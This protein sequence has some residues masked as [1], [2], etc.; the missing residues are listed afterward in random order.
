MI[1]KNFKNIT[2]ISTTFVLSS[3]ILVFANNPTINNPA[4]PVLMAYQPS[5]QSNLNTVN[6]WSEFIQRQNV[7]IESMQNHFPVVVMAAASENQTP[8][9]WLA[10]SNPFLMSGE[11]P[12]WFDSWSDYIEWLAH[13]WNGEQN[14]PLPNFGQHAPFMLPNLPENWQTD[15]LIWAMINDN[16]PAFLGFYPGWQGNWSNWQ[17]GFPGGGWNPNW[18]NWTFPD[19]NWSGWS[20]TLPTNWRS[21]F[22]NSFLNAMPDGW[23]PTW[24]MPGN[25]LFGFNNWNWHPDLHWSWGA[26]W[27]QSWGYV[28]NNPGWGNPWGNWDWSYWGDWN[29]WN[30]WNWNTQGNPNWNLPRDWNDQD[31]QNNPWNWNPTA[32]ATFGDRFIEEEVRRITGIHNGPLLQQHLDRVTTL[33][34]VFP[35]SHSVTNAS[36]SG[37]NRLTRLRSFRFEPQN[38]T[39]NQSNITN[40]NALSGLSNLEELWM[41]GHNI[42]NINALNGL[43]RLTDVSLRNNNVTDFSSLHDRNIRVTY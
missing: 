30:N 24:G 8:P 19:A 34:I 18:G 11:L 43:N 9:W 37:V 41:D 1:H 36:L 32:P 25:F 17:G 6:D 13:W 38:L 12:D 27:D 29:Q 16:F 3:P 23:T 14:I 20:G 39:N 7:A 35:S 42:N 4:E 2:I 22:S 5:N 21:Y 40:L 26:T 33:D 15:P 31:L 28:W 10:Y